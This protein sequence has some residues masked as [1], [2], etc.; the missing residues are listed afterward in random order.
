MKDKTTIRCK[1]LGHKFT[2]WFG[3]VDH[4]KHEEVY[5]EELGREIKVPTEDAEVFNVGR[6]RMCQRR[7]C[8]QWDEERW[9]PRPGYGHENDDTMK[10]GTMNHKQF[11]TAIRKRGERRRDQNRVG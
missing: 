4:T 10:C 3:V 11:L 9:E 6:F 1:I 5:I 2:P 8:G 7:G